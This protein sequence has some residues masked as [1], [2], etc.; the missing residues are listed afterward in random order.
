MEQVDT[1]LLIDS[2]HALLNSVDEIE[3]DIELGKALSNRNELIILIAS[4]L[5]SE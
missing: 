5:S 4:R 2:L 3:D 1:E